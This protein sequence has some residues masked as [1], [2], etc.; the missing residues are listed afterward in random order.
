MALDFSEELNI[1]YSHMRDDDPTSLNDDFIRTFTVSSHPGDLPDNEFEITTRLHGPVTAF[2]K[3]QRPSSRNALEVKLRGFGGDFQI[4]TSEEQNVLP[5]VAGGVGLTPLLGQ[6][7]E[8]DIDKVRLIWIIR[9]E[10]LDFVRDIFKQYPALVKGTTL[11]LTGENQS[12]KTAGKV[13]DMVKLGATV[14]MGR[15]TSDIGNT[16]PGA[17]TWYLCASQSLRKHLLEWLK[18]KKVEF[19]NF[20][21]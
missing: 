5:F 12:T 13:E 17:Q 21:Y 10:D 20:D 9:S 2:L 6:L 1:G 11:F 18:E 14:K 7:K 16:V 15:P 8:L 3:T 4:R 19:E